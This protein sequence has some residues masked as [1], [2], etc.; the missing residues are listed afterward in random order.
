MDFC[1]SCNDFASS[2]HEACFPSLLGCLFHIPH[3]CLPHAHLVE[4]NMPEIA[5]VPLNGLVALHL[6]SRDLISMTQGVSIKTLDEGKEYTTSLDLPPAVRPHLEKL[7]ERCPEALAVICRLVARSVYLASDLPHSILELENPIEAPDLAIV[8][9]EM[10]VLDELTAILGPCRGVS[11]GDEVARLVDEPVPG[12]LKYWNAW[13]HGHVMS[14]VKEYRSYWSEVREVYLAP[15]KP[16]LAIS[17]D[18]AVAGGEGNDQNRLLDC[19][20]LFKCVHSCGNLCSGT[21]FLIHANASE[22]LLLP[23]VFFI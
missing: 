16:A 1:F 6:L 21:F 17:A 4:A 10:D 13:N 7:K 20:E 8:V 15:P 5:T 12:Y 14:V 3:L 22:E 18:P 9:K 2:F 11:E 23:C 19:P